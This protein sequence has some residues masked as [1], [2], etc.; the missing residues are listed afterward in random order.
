MKL[1]NS[2]KLFLNILAIF[3]SAFALY[4]ASI[5]WI[6]TNLTLREG[7]SYL[8]SASVATTIILIFFILTMTISII[9]L[10]KILFKKN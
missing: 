9:Y 7:Q 3:A 5:L 8:N 2:D 4:W 1:N 10:I 6:F